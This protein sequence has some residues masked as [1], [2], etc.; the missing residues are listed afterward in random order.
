MYSR[1]VH[2]L[3]LRSLQTA[4]TEGSPQVFAQRH[5]RYLLRIV[6]RHE[7]FYALIM[8]YVERYYLRKYSECSQLHMNLFTHV[9]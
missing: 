5:P 9:S 8:I 1:S 7:E 6:N 3:P 4:L 2:P